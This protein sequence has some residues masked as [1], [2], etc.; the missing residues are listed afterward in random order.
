MFYTCFP[1]S[2]NTYTYTLRAFINASFNPSSSKTFTHPPALPLS[3]ADPPSLREC[4]WRRL[5]PSVGHSCS[6]A[7]V[8]VVRHPPAC[9]VP[10]HPLTHPLLRSSSLLHHKCFFF[11]RRR[12]VLPERKDYVF[13][14]TCVEQCCESLNGYRKA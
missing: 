12:I 9:L 1:L 14:L 7:S 8:L 2:V 6:V 3:L 10:P 4:G 5:Q 13:C 11:F